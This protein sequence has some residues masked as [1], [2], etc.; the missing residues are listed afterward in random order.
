MLD[1]ELKELWQQAGTQARLM[2]NENQMVTT[3][4]KAMA[5][6]EGKIKKRNLAEITAAIFVIICF[7]IYFVLQDALVAKAG[8]GILVG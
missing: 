4:E 5:E 2:M 8:A 1:K 3:M 6:F 7:G